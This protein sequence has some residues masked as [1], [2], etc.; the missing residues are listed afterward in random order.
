MCKED[1]KEN[2]RFLHF[3]I[4]DLRFNLG[5][6]TILS[7]LYIYAHTICIHF[8]S[9]FHVIC[10]FLFRPLLFISKYN[11]FTKIPKIYSLVHRSHRQ[12]FPSWIVKHNLCYASLEL[13]VEERK[14][15]IK[16]VSIQ[17]YCSSRWKYIYYPSTVDIVNRQNKWHENS[18][19]LICQQLRMAKRKW[20]TAKCAMPNKYTHILVTN[21]LFTN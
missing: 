19:L 2:L 18:N 21:W 5:H 17:W 8:F 13:N 9:T 11:Y 16:L 20:L 4:T 15:K 10:H 14:Q 12:S 1:E 7:E 6:H 3:L